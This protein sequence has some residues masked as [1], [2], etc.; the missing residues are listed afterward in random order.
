ML[1]SSMKT[2]P[3]NLP[4]CP[5]CGERF[6]KL[7]DGKIPTHD[8]PKPCRAVCRGTGQQP[9]AHEA[10]PL[11]KDD[12]QQEER[13]FVEAAR[14]ELKLYGFAV[15][16]EVAGMRAKPTGEMPCPLCGNVLRYRLAKSNGHCA[17]RCKTN[18]CINAME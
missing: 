12:P 9:K 15:V 17:A 8:F 1:D 6:E 2:N 13:D 16:K 5:L 4:E 18:H 3:K 14:L 7:K 11:W 10:T